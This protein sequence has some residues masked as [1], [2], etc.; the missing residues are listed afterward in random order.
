[1]SYI[2]LSPQLEGKGCEVVFCSGLY[3][4]RLLRYM[5]EIQAD[6][7]KYAK[8]IAYQ[9]ASK[10]DKI[11]ADFLVDNDI[12]D[13]LYMFGTAPGVADHVK[14]S[15]LSG[16]QKL[17]YIRLSSIGAEIKKIRH[18]VYFLIFIVAFFLFGIG[19]TLSGG[20]K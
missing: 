9:A 18:A 19:A 2:L 17:L 8:E 3:P 11:K 4:E 12:I 7:L 1:M 20:Y 5:N 14:L 6:E 16:P 15:D 13:F 10:R